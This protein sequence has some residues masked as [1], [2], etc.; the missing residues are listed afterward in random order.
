MK[1]AAALVVQTLLLLPVHQAAA[2]NPLVLNAGQADPHLRR[3]PDG[4]G[5]LL[6]ATHDYSPN[7]TGFLMKDWELWHSPDLVDWSLKTVLDPASAVPWGGQPTECWATDGAFHNNAWYWYLSVGTNHV[8]VVQS[9]TSNSTMK[10]ATAMQTLLGPWKDPLGKALLS[11]DLAKTL[12]PPATFR[13]PAVFQDPSD[14]SWYIISGVF[15]YY[16]ARLEDDMVSLAETPKLVVVDPNGHS[17]WGPYGQKTDDKP[18]IHYFDG[19]CYCGTF[20]CFQYRQCN[21]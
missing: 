20:L 11:P 2:R 4:D 7:N 8:G 15:D 12:S 3:E 10:L 21:D 17:A 19:T 6:F 5:F 1:H 13:D 18:Y 14:D 9:N 16:I